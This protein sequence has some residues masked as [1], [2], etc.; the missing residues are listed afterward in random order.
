MAFL[1]FS[2]DLSRLSPL[3]PLNCFPIHFETILIRFLCI[4]GFWSTSGFLFILHWQGRFFIDKCAVERSEWGH[5]YI[6]RFGVVCSAIRITN[7][8][9]QWLPEYQLYYMQK[10]SSGLVGRRFVTLKSIQGSTGLCRG[11]P[12]DY[13]IILYSSIEH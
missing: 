7:Y 5:A 11:K 1:T 4:L 2:Q 6:K 8:Y 10:S 13:A 9:Y 3:N 12:F